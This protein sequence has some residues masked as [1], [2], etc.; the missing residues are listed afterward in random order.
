MSC[1]KQKETQNT[2]IKLGEILLLLAVVSAI[3]GKL[4]SLSP[5]RPFSQFSPWL[6]K[7]FF[8]FFFP[9][10]PEIHSN[11]HFLSQVF[12]N[13]WEHCWETFVDTGASQKGQKCCETVL[14]TRQKHTSPPKCLNLQSRL[15]LFFFFFFFFISIQQWWW[16][17]KFLN[18]GQHLFLDIDAASVHVCVCWGSHVNIVITTNNCSGRGG[19]GIGWDQ[20]YE[21]YA[22]GLVE[23][24]NGDRNFH[25]NHWHDWETQDL[26]LSGQT[27]A[28]FMCSCH[29]TRTHP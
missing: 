21:S 1:T 11:D 22:L 28:R 16:W 2:S 7:V 12:Q 6:F 26:D 9:D 17:W 8:F 24:K 29:H 18:S 3:F 5:D 4:F 13:W 14:L 27:K 15:W 10:F 25:V 20:V 23:K 19:G